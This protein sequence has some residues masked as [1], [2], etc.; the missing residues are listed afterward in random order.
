MNPL[1]SLGPLR[2]SSYGFVLLVMIGV[3]W[4]WAARRIT[5]RTQRDPDGLLWSIVLGAW[6]GG[7]LWHLAGSS[8]WLAEITN[9]RSLEYAWPGVCVG[10]VVALLLAQRRAGWQVLPILSDIALPTLIAQAGGAFGMFVAGMGMGVPWDG[11]WAVQMAGVYRHPVQLY[12]ALMA[13][14][15]AGVCAYVPRHT[16]I[17]AYLVLLGAIAA[18]WLVVEGF[19][20][21]AVTMPGGIHLAQL[22]GLGILIVVI[23]RGMMSTT[24]PAPIDA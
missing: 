20:S 6:L 24:S 9:W 23:E 11:L 19:R 7:R 17:P 10:A 1:I 18:N 3:W 14:L 8:V 2:L 22:L 4:W 5:A 13:L 21:A 15:G 16:S 12:E